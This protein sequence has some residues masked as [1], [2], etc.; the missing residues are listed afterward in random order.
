MKT[1]KRLVLFLAAA[2]CLWLPLAGC[3]D[4]TSHST[5]VYMLLDTSGTYARELRKAQAILNYLL[6]TLQPGDSLAVARID[7]GSFS[8]KDIVAK[9]T[10]DRRPSASNAQK[11]A[12]AQKVDDFVKSVRGSAHTDITG[13]LL[14]AVEWLNET[15]AGRKYIL[16]YSD[17]EEDLVKGQ[18]RDIPLQLKGFRVVALNVTKLRTDNIDPRRYLN[19]LDYW[20][21]RVEKGGGEF[22][23]INDLERLEKILAD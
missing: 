5:G 10:F 3:A 1:C 6:G 21:E 23:V 18:V 8:E 15:G 4:T 14:Q 13:G 7:S 12:F 16:I 19:R 11:R 20:R 22:R 2:V 9:V 17:L